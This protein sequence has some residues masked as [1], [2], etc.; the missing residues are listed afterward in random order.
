VSYYVIYRSALPAQMGDSL[1]Y[2]VSTDYT[3]TGAAGD[4]GSNHYY[5]VKAV[6]SEGRKSA[7]SNQV[8]EFDLEL[9]LPDKAGSPE[10]RSGKR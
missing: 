4:S 1:G 8:G 3:D 10:G 6:D 2:S 7:S 9:I 5:T